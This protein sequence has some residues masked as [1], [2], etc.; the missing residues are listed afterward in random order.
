M[1]TGRLSARV[2]AISISPTKR[3]AQSHWAGA[4]TRAW[5][6][7]GPAQDS[8]VD[9]AGT[10][11]EGALGDGVHSGVLRP[12]RPLAMLAPVGPERA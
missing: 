3:P 5:Q 1:N 9:G 7:P 6:A 4:G 12:H 10:T 8:G 2:Q 11:E